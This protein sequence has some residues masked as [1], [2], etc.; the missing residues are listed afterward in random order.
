MGG[1]GA[2]CIDVRLLTELEKMA[3]DGQGLDPEFGESKGAEPFAGGV[4]EIVRGD[5]IES[6]RQF[7]K[8]Q[9][10]GGVAPTH[11]C[12]Q[13]RPHSAG[14][15]TATARFEYLRQTIGTS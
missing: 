1:A 6:F 5:V 4:T 13:I 11:H 9:R 2:V 8:V 12:L 7:R 10:R 3:G 15:Q 14:R